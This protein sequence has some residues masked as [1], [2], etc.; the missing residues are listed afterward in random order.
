MDTVCL[1]PLWPV[2]YVQDAVGYELG[3]ELCSRGFVRWEGRSGQEPAQLRS[4][5][6]R[7][8]E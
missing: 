4:E 1:Q 3:A 6:A 7:L 2:I 8:Y 5:K